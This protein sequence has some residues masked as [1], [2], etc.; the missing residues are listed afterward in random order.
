[1]RSGGSYRVNAVQVSGWR[2]GGDERTEEKK[3]DNYKGEEERRGDEKRERC[4]KI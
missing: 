2:R 3:S 4:R 1:M